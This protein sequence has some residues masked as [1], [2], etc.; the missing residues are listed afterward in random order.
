M[1][2][3]YSIRPCANGVAVLAVQIDADD[4][5]AM[6]HVTDWLRDKLGSSVVVV[7]AVIGER[8]TCRRCH[9]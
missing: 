1:T 5:D 4:A 2:Q 8:A 3:N 6:R 7:G 9:Q